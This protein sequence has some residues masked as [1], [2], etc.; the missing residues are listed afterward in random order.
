MYTDW[1]AHFAETTSLIVEA[2][3]TILIMPITMIGPR[4]VREKGRIAAGYDERPLQQE[5]MAPSDDHLRIYLFMLSLHTLY[6]G[7]SETLSPV[8]TRHTHNGW[9]AGASLLDQ[10]SFSKVEC[11]VYIQTCFS[12]NAWLDHS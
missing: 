11:C 4:K 9:S 12:M 8:H 2:S 10:P 5:E 6:L 1:A 7:I 3:E